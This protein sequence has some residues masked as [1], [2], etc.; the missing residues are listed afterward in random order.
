MLLRVT[1]SAL[2]CSVLAVQDVSSFRMVEPLRC[3]IPPDHVEVKTI[4]VGM[5]LH[6]CRSRRT[7]PRE[8]CMKAMVPLQLASNLFVAFEAFE[9]GSPGRDFVT[10][11]AIGIARETLVSARQGSRRN[12]SLH[13]PANDEN[14]EKQGRRE[15]PGSHDPVPTACTPARVLRSGSCFPPVHSSNLACLSPRTL[16]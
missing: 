15:P 7:R 3:R 4:V 9:R 5:A 12:L 11:R 1:S 16:P 10:L 14:K 13:R 6:A 8:S 2:H